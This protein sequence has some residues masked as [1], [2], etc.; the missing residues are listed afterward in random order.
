MSYSTG[1]WMKNKASSSK[2][3]VVIIGAGISG[4][5]SA[6][7]LAKSGF[8]VTVIE[9]NSMSGGRAITW[10]KNGFLF[11]MGPS[12]YLM[13]EVFEKFFSEFNYKSSDFYKLK[14]LDP[15]YRV[16]FEGEGIVDVPADKKGI[17]ELF[18]SFEENGTKKLK[19][20]LIDAEYK[21]NIAMKDFLYKEY[22]TIFDFFSPQ[23]IIQA[24]KLRLF[25]SIDSFASRFFKSDKAKKI[26]EYSMVFL[27]GSP[28][29]TPALYSIMSHVDLTLGVY[30]PMGGIWMLP[31]SFMK[32]G[33]EQ[34]V[35]FFFNS[36]VEKILVNEEGRV[37]GVKTK[38]KIIPADIVLSSADYPHTEMDLLEKKYQ[39]YS[40]KYWD[41]RVV[42]PSAVLM[43]LGFKKKIKNFKHHNLFLA[44][45]WNVHF[46]EIFNNPAWPKNPSYY[47]GCPSKSD[48]SVAPKGME[49]V[50]VLVPVA[51]GLKDSEKIKEKMFDYIINDLEKQTGEKL[52]ESMVVKR[53]FA[54]SDFSN[55]YNSYKGSALGIAHTLFQ[56]AVFRPAHKS[57]KVKGLFYAGNY[58]HPGIGV[59][60]SLI[61]AQ[62]VAD[63]VKKEK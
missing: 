24:P 30:Y 11:D 7:L 20:Y 15:C 1:F 22:A 28:S 57:K 59:P 35:K 47:V 51:A 12:W 53:L 26:L 5:A 48:P 18:D 33:K 54:Q 44:K 8:D 31:N 25:E 55:L 10:G 4:L 63:L 19:K 9:K 14:R 38:K 16:F 62:I 43:Y 2:K 32:I 41:K 34:G 40:E 52:K 13:P 46:R 58:T 17:N 6:A 39:S 60:I 42:A 23:V 36:P 50:F 21:Y 45:D 37:S 56:T 29:N 49:N 27:G 3:K 61:S